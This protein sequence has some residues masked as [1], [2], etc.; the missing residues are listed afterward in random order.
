M[1][2]GLCQSLEQRW[3]EEEGTGVPYRG[4]GYMGDTD[5]TPAHSWGSQVEFEGLSPWEG[6]VVD[7]Q[8]GESGSQTTWLLALHSIT[9]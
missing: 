9:Y 5:P 2:R 3:M 4:S 8:V 1:F 6:H 7:K